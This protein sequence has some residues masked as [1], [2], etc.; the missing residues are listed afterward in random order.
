MSLQTIEQ[1]TKEHAADRT[2]L[3]ERVQAL[4]DEIDQAKRRKV[5]GIKSAVSKARDS[6]LRLASAIEHEPSAFEQPRTRVF[7]GIKVGLQKAKGKL[8]WLSA[9][10]VIELVRKHFPERADVLIKTTEKPVKKALQGLPAGDLKKLGCTIEETGD[11]VVIQPINTEIDELVDALLG[12][13]ADGEPQ[14]A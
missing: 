11:Q 9:E 5:P 1:L 2:V 7:H 12:N 13:G 4:H 10:K 14:E 3:A 6:R 8:S